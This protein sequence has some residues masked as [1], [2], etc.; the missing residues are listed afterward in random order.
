M[1]KLAVQSRQARKVTVPR[2]T[3]FV[4]VPIL[5]VA[6]NVRRAHEKIDSCKVTRVLGK[7]NLWHECADHLLYIEERG[8][9][10]AGGN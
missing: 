9:V 6:P 1:S 7:W 10:S 8:L 2:S 5:P 4:H 3:K